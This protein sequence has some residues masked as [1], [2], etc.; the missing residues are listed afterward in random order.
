M[1]STQRYFTDA[2]QFEFTLI[3]EKYTSNVVASQAVRRRLRAYY[4]NHRCETPVRTR[5]FLLR[6]NFYVHLQYNKV[7]EFGTYLCGNKNSRKYST[8][9]Y[10]QYTVLSGLYTVQYMYRFVLSYF[11]L[12]SLS[13]H[14][15]LKNS[16][17]YCNVL[18]FAEVFPSP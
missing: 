17:Q 12:F 11:V 10:E 9:M 3:I 6:P 13:I 14:S 16:Q 7:K 18:Y 4:R 8:L 1:Y 2:F 15:F 5:A